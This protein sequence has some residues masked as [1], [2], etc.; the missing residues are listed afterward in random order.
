MFL[1]TFIWFGPT[2]KCLIFNF[3]LFFLQYRPPLSFYFAGI[4]VSIPLFSFSQPCPTRP[5]ISVYRLL[6]C[7]NV[8]KNY[9]LLV[10][11]FYCIGL[12]CTQYSWPTWRPPC[13]FIWSVCFLGAL[14]R[15]IPLTHSQTHFF[16]LLRSFIH[17]SS[18][19]QR[20]Q[21]HQFPSPPS[22]LWWR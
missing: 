13:Y 17:M 5:I 8:C 15:H 3:F 21:P 22:P 7:R 2:E 11:G 1:R 6:Y 19:F 16:P 12:S 10:L 20:S 9:F 18:S 14:F 4:P